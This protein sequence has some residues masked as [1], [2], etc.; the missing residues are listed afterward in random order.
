MLRFFAWLTGDGALLL[1][2]AGCLG[3]G[4]AVGYTA[5]STHYKAKIAHIEAEQAKREAEIATAV[6]ETQ[7]A[8]A[9]QI[10]EALDAAQEKTVQAQRDAAAANAANRRLRDALA[11]YRAKNASPACSGQGEQDS[12]PIGVLVDLLSRMGEIGERISRYADQ[13][14]IA[15]AACEAAWPQ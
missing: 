15:G 9:Q 2:I 14:K 12:D 5:T 10:M 13:V 3:A 7:Q 4:A 1:L 6:M 11:A 8:Q